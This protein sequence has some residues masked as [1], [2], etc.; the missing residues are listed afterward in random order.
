V[1]WATEG[2]GDEVV[3]GPVLCGTGEVA[4]VAA[5]VVIS[6]G[7]VSDHC[8]LLSVERFLLGRKGGIL[9]RSASLT[10]SV[11]YFTN[12]DTFFF[13]K[14]KSFQSCFITVEVYILFEYPTQKM[15]KIYVGW[16]IL[17]SHISFPTFL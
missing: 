4:K 15:P 3:S 17:L 2:C 6:L 1:V 7:Q 14:M 5:T 13:D 16:G 10:A 12:V 9:Y 8:F 11:I